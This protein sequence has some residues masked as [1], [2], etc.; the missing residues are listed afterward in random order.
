MEFRGLTEYLEDLV[1][2]VDTPP[3]SRLA[4]GAQPI[5]RYA[6][7]FGPLISIFLRNHPLGP[8]AG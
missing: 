2:P 3:L 1:A 6:L 7:Q 5:F 4:L 8:G